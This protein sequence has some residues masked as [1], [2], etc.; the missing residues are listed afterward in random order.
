MI[1]ARRRAAGASSARRGEQ[2]DAGRVMRRPSTKINR[3]LYRVAVG[4]C[5]CIHVLKLWR[6][7]TT[8]QPRYFYLAS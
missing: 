3:K 1:Y 6:V 8:P 5:Q 4:I 2:A 7:V